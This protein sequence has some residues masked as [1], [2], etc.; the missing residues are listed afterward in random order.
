MPGNSIGP[1]AVLVRTLQ[2]IVGALLSGCL[3]FLGIVLV[4]AGGPGN[5]PNRPML[6]YAACAIAAAAV[7]ARAVI[8]GIIVAQARRRILDGVW[9]AAQGD[10]AAGSA[11]SLDQNGDAGKL[12]QILML[13][14]IVAA[15]I[16]EGAV[17]LL[18]IAYLVERWPLSLAFAVVLLVALAA[19]FPTH[20][21]AAG[22]MQEQMRL[23]DEERSF[24]DRHNF[25]R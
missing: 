6:T 2:I 19:L 21:R 1:S 15:A 11:G 17:F 5:S 7:V 25:D 14:T 4:V 3:L 9:N 8:P 16:L 23:L 20:S 22:W 13:R 10:R 18:L 24:Q 12:A